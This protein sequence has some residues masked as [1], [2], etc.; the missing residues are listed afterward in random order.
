MENGQNKD[1]LKMTE[2]EVQGVKEMKDMNRGMYILKIKIVSVKRV[3]Q[4]LKI[5]ASFMCILMN[6]LFF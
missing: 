2:Q 1:K 5:H 6:E 3:F 4:N